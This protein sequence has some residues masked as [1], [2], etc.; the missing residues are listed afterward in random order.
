LREIY[1]FHDFRTSESQTAENRI[2][3]DSLQYRIDAKQ[4]G[5]G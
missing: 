1:F 2:R 4:T 3:S 5:L